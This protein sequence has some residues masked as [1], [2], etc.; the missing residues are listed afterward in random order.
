MLSTC[1][2]ALGKSRGASVLV[3]FTHHRPR[4]ADRDMDFFTKARE[5]GWV[6]EEVLTRKYPVR[7]KSLSVWS[8]LTCPDAV[9]SLCSLRILGKR[10]SAQP[11]TDGVYHDRRICEARRKA[12]C[13]IRTHSVSQ[14]N[15]AK[16]RNT[17][18]QRATGATEYIADE[19]GERVY[20][21]S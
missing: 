12:R 14:M 10:K 17:I 9:A 15:G 2:N 7:G 5:R 21:V 16:D 4:L 11:S 13:T 3:F 8:N 20:D 18:D 1:E 6:C 19:W